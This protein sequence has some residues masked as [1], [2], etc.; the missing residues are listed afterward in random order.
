MICPAV[1]RTSPGMSTLSFVGAK[2]VDELL[3]QY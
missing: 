2:H 3:A 1:S